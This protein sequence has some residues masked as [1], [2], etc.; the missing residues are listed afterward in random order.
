MEKERGHSG[1]GVM[2]GAKLLVRP[3]RHWIFFE[4]S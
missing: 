4:I 2:L 1:D 3:D